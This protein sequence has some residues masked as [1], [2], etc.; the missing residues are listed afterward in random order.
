MAEGWEGVCAGNS[1]N[2]RA[3][4]KCGKQGVVKQKAG[5]QQWDVRKPPLWDQA[6]AGLSLILV[7]SWL[8][9]FTSLGL[10]F[11]SGNEAKRHPPRWL[12]WGSNTV[13]A[14]RYM[15]HMCIIYRC[16]CVGM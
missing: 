15:I 5:I 4:E 14:Y 13:C 9:C 1:P 8:G 7:P 10:S 2:S 12:L 16:I 11:Y 6:H 3:R